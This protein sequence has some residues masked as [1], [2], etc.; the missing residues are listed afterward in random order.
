[1]A[2]N[3]FEIPDEKV[4]NLFFEHQRNKTLLLLQRNLS[5][6]DDDAKDI[7]QEACLALYQNIQTG[8][9]IE[10]TSSLS[11]YFTSICLNKGKKLLE[12]CPNNISFEGAIENTESDEYS[13]SQI[14]TILGMGDGITNEQRATMR[15][16]VQDLPSPC[17]EILWGYYGD[18]L[19]MKEIAELIGFNGPDSVKSKKSQCMSK[20]KDRFMKIIKQFYE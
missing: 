5:L 13:T 19:Q 20:L 15:D 9:L 3:I 12:R 1:M 16:I 6:S 17:E 8:K 11:T 4:L 2:K 18:N 7:Y 10:L 14:E